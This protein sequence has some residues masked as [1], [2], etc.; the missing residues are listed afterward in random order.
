MDANEVAQMDKDSCIILPFASKP[1][2][3]K[4]YKPF[5]DPSYLKAKKY[6]PYTIQL[7]FSVIKRKPAYSKSPGE[8]LFSG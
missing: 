6:G 3:D 1:I 7:K 8:I 4:K 5:H 2:I